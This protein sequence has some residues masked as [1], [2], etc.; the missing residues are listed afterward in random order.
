ME[1]IC[2]IET[3][4][5]SIIGIIV[6]LIHL[7]CLHHHDRPTLSQFVPVSYVHRSLPRPPSW[8]LNQSTLSLSVSLCH[9]VTTTTTIMIIESAYIVTVSVWSRTR[10]IAGV[11]APGGVLCIQSSLIIML[12]SCAN[13]FIL[14]ITLVVFDERQLQTPPLLEKKPVSNNIHCSRIAPEE[15]FCNILLFNTYRA[16]LQW[17]NYTLSP[18]SPRAHIVMKNQSYL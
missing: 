12:V 7:V 5:S 16:I 4:P 18:A 14:I 3:P 6:Q 2:D 15:I 13:I 17:L 9:C 8:L 1:S 10:T 11:E